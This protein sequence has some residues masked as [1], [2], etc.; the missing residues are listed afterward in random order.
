MISSDESLVAFKPTTSVIRLVSS[1]P[2]IKR[3][4]NKPSDSASVFASSSTSNSKL[5]KDASEKHESLKIKRKKNCFRRIKLFQE[6]V[7]RPQFS[8]EFNKTLSIIEI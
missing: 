5:E 2:N 3:I 7:F 8:L 6:H 4:I 1:N